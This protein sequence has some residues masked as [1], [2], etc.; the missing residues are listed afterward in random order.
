MAYTRTNNTRCLTFV[1]DYEE[2][3]YVEFRVRRSN[4]IKSLEVWAF[5]DVPEGHMVKRTCEYGH[6]HMVPSEIKRDL[7]RVDLDTS[8]I[9]EL[10]SFLRQFVQ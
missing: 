9:K 5:K 4:G 1:D 3:K 6:E 2:D 10:L 8:E 7:V